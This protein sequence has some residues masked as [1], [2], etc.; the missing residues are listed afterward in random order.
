MKTEEESIENLK[1]KCQIL[2]YKCE[3]V[4]EIILEMRARTKNYYENMSRNQTDPTIITPHWYQANHAEY[5][6]MLRIHKKESMDYA[7]VTD[8]FKKLETTQKV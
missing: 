3:N 4:Q 6:T 7:C 5:S 8:A 2:H 1:K